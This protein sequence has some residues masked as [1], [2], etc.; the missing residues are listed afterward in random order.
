MESITTESGPQVQLGAVVVTVKKPKLKDYKRFLKLVAEVRYTVD[1]EALTGSDPAK[2]AQAFEA[3]ADVPDKVA[4]LCSLASDA[5]VEQ[6]GEA[7]LEQVLG[8]LVAC[9][10]HANVLK[11]LGEAVKKMA[12]AEGQAPKEDQA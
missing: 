10:K 1:F 11:A 6:A 3:L 4:E 8:L 2:S 5:T 9:I 7:D 12:G